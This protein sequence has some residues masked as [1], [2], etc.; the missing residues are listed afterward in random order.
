VS[1]WAYTCISEAHFGTTFFYWE[2]N[3]RIKIDKGKFGWLVFNGSF[4]RNR[5]TRDCECKIYCL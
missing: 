2:L 1:V 3:T 5:T 4:N